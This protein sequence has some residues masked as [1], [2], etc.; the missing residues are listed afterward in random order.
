MGPAAKPVVCT[1]CSQ[2]C[3][4][5]AHVDD[6]RVTRLT[7][8]RDHPSSRGFICPK[9]SGA[10]LLHYD[11]A[12]LHRPLKRVGPRGSG[13]W[14]EIG[15]DQALDEI[16]DSIRRLAAA[17]GPEAVAYSFGTLHAADWGV[18]ER[19][20]N[21]FGSP[22]SIG[23]DKVCYGP[24]TYAEVLTYGWG[25]AMYAAPVV[26]TTGCEV[27]WGFR[28]SAS[29]PLLWGAITAARKAGTKLIVIDP[30]RTHEAEKADLFLQNRP[31]SDAA[32]AMGLINV[33]V[34]EGLYDAD[35]VGNET[36]GFE[37][38]ARRAEEYPPERVA[39]ITWVPADQLVAAARMLTTNSPA[40]IHGSNG[41]CQ[42]GTGA[43]QAGRALAC[44]IAITGNLGVPGGHGLAGPPRDI[45]A[46]GD[47]MLCDALSAQQRAKRLG[48]DA[49]P[50]IGSGYGD[51]S[52]ATSHA[53]HGDRH[54]LSWCSTGHEPTLWR[55]ITTEQP[56]P[57]KALILQCHNAVGS[58]ANAHAA[59]D[60]LL[61][62]NLDLLVVQDLFLNKTSSLADYVLPAAHWLEKPFYSAAY[63]YAGWAGDY[64]EAK[65]APLPAEHPSDY[66]LWRDLGRRLGQAEHWPDTAEEFWDSL[67]QPAGLSYD[68]VCLHLGP[69]MGEGAQSTPPRRAPGDRRYGTP[70]G[71]VEL[72]S[73]LLEK[74]GLDPLPG[75]EQPALFDG[76]GDEF[77][78]VL[79]TG[80]RHLRG[81][82]QNAQQLAIYRDKYP[83]PVVSMHPDTA[84][85]AGI[86]AGDWVE[87]ATPVGAVRQKARI[88]DILQPGVVHAD[89]WWYPERAGDQE[90]PFGFWATNIN[91]CTDDA[92]GSCDAVMGSWLLRALPCQ[93]TPARAPVAVGGGADVEEGGG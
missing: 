88:T 3:G 51:V 11:P 52:E 17:H 89:R 30:Q 10:H 39:E 76:A 9:G 42:T 66:D 35:F 77:P 79:T 71:K 22:N 24:N 45:V 60:A 26:G 37:D 63:G 57:V 12:R 32:L 49:Y 25:P 91:V 90:D 54:A 36:I 8:D 14:Q 43:V 82:H 70:S 62:E 16:A 2:Q 31:G 34:A 81:F 61:S 21:L 55:A 75:W 1:S 73:S 92:A 20:M 84:A 48:A 7:G 56:Y 38:L 19:F 4:L 50:S 58:G 68:E 29:M 78:L 69:I 85:H 67:L 86:V 72:R 83:D 59:A 65:P 64:V 23:Q 40:I 41:L 27:L 53:W 80:G 18:G 87:I 28:P 47:A 13:Q 5:L 46:N 44:L 15:W 6:G 33:I 74:W 93:V